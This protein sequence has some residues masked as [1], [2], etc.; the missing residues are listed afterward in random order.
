VGELDK[1]ADASLHVCQPGDL[2]NLDRAGCR[3]YMYRF[4]HSALLSET[5]SKRASGHP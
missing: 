5:I 2:D 1:A 4:A 3:V